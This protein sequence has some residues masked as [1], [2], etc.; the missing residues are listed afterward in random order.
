MPSAKI[1]DEASAGVPSAT[2]TNDLHNPKPLPATAATVKRPYQYDVPRR[3][4]PMDGEP[5]TIQ[6]DPTSELAQAL[7]DADEPVVL[8]S[9]GVRYR[10]LREEDALFAG[11]DPSR[12]RD[13]L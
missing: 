1:G 12:V 6:I 2:S 13:A 3:R 8:D 5:L 4:Q 7:A 9:N 11:Y 10:V